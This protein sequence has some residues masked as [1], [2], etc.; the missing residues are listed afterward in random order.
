[1]TLGNEKL[2]RVTGTDRH[3]VD[4]IIRVRAADYN[5]AMHKAS[6]LPH[7]LIVVHSCVLM[8]EILRRWRAHGGRV[9]PAASAVTP[10]HLHLSAAG[11]LARD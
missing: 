7:E 1:M 3:H 8:E 2:W 11:H 10:V 9:R 5:A 4:H 6:Q